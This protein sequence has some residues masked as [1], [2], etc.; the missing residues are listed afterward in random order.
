VPAPISGFQSD[1]R[2]LGRE[3]DSLDATDAPG[4]LER[5]LRLAADALAGRPRPELVLIG[6]GAWDDAILK[7]IHLS[8]FKADLSAID[9]QG[10]DLRY[11]SVG[12]SG[13]NAGITAFAVRRYRA[14]QTAYEVL[15][16]V[17]S[18]AKAP[19]TRSLELSQDG[20]VVE[21]EPL[22][23][24]PGERVQRRYPN[25]AGEGTRLTAR[26]TG[27]RD[28]LPLDDNAYALLPPRKKLKVLLVTA[29]DLFLEGALL[30]DENLEVTKVAPTGYHAADGAKY[31]A[32][33]L[34][35]FTPE[36]PPATNALYIDPRG[37][38]SPFPVRGEIPAPL[39]TEVAANHPLMRW[40][41]LKD[42]NISRASK[43]VLEPGDVAVASALRD[44]IIA[45]REKD[46][47]KIA[48]LGFELRKSDLPLRVAFPV[49]V[50]NALEWFGGN[51]GNLVASYSTAHP[52]RLPAPPGVT[53]LTVRGPGIVAKA[54]VHDGR[55]TFFG[56]NAGYYET[57]PGGRVFAANLASPSESR[58]E[59]RATITV[60]GQTLRAPE[61]GKVGLRRALWAW[62]AAAALL[63]LFVEWWTYNRRV[64][65]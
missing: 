39:V 63:L 64:T 32:V 43:L 41:T 9:L 50:V 1:D 31:D 35:G 25:L 65:V 3:I 19:M 59:P 15:V 18:F 48:A 29:G 56:M 28:A 61:P 11:V 46:G 38:H 16:E 51:D 20:E 47:R 14:N 17:Q 54:P 7:R 13:D 53:E 45:A 8:P 22:K 26:L 24:A 55:A 33:V 42:L 10:V 49:L 52:W 37:E 30:L 40:V 4:D 62:L 21:V 44:P 27:P 36:E 58:V 57:Q 23:L 12:N 5:A 2:E 60:D 34:D 6:D